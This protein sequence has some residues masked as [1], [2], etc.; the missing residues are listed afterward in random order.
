L[1]GLVGAE[2]HRVT[3]VGDCFELDRG[4]LLHPERDVAESPK[5]LA[6]VSQDASISSKREM[7]ISVGR[8][9]NLLTV[10]GVAVD[11]RN[12]GLGIVV[13]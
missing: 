2:L 12:R 9:D 7:W 6:V 10:R 8:I 13:R 3:M 5:I 11:M 1:P 4:L